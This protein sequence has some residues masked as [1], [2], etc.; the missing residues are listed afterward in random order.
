MTD[1]T[2]TWCP[3]K[4][5]GSLTIA[6][7]DRFLKDTE[8]MFELILDRIQD[9]TEKLYPMIRELSDNNENAA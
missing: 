9:E 3:K 8:E 6:D 5:A 7:H 1:Y 4:Q 2:K